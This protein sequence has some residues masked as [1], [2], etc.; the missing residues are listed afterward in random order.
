M[1]RWLLLGFLAAALAA[2]SFADV[3]AG[4]MAYANGDFEKALAELL[5][6]AEAGDLLAQFTIA[7]MY[8]TGSG[9]AQDDAAAVEWYGR[10]AVQG[11]RDSQYALGYMLLNGRGVDVPDETNACRWFRAAAEQNHPA[12]QYQLGYAYWEGSG[13]PHDDGEAVS[14]FERAAEQQNPNAQYYLGIAYQEG[15][16][17]GRNEATAREWFS[18]A[19]GQGHAK[20]QYRYGA[21]LSEGIGGEAD[22][23]EAV[24]WLRKAA[25]RGVAEAQ[26]ELGEAYADG[27]GVARDDGRAAEFYLQ[28]AKQGNADAQNRLGFAYANGRGVPQDYQEAVRWYRMAIENSHQGALSGLRMLFSAGD[29]PMADSEAVELY[30][31]GSELGIGPA[32]YRLAEAYREGR[33]VEVNEAEAARWY[34]AAAEQGHGESQYRLAVAYAKGRGVP[35]D[36][37]E[38]LRW[39]R[40]AADQGHVEAQLQMAYVYAQGDGVPQSDATSVQWYRLAAENGSAIAQYNLGFAYANG[41]GVPNDDQEAVRW[42]RMAADQGYAD[43]QSNLGFMLFN[44]RGV[45]Q[46]YIQAH[47][48][49]NLAA[50]QGDDVAQKNRDALAALMTPEQLARAQELAGN[51]RPGGTD[52]VAESGRGASMTGPATGSGETDAA[53]DYSGQPISSATGFTVSQEGHIVTV[54]HMLAGCTSVSVRGLQPRQPAPVLLEDA[55]TNLA[56]LGPVAS[57]APPLAFSDNTD[58]HIGDD[59]VVATYPLGARQSES[60]MVTTGELRGTVGPGG[61]TRMMQLT[62]PVGQGSDGG[63]LL[64]ASGNAI[65]MVIS[66]LN[67]LQPDDF[68]SEYGL[69]IKVEVVRSLLDGAGVRYQIRPSNAP[70]EVTAAGEAAKQSAVIV[71]CW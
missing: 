33:G 9:V 22:A 32:Q 11:N 23:A 17:T 47:M 66:E 53:P 41:T 57:P 58:F 6:A 20:A 28:A 40:S 63:P 37:A 30:R 64:D 61:D 60:M 35:V 71:E 26:Y 36:A 12:A 38:S 56:L 1:R 45:P 50:S 14:W 69:A 51:W 13:L 4:M 19:A 43:A 34:L 49:T 10:A 39:Y 21:M 44:G 55:A 15:R 46:D 24:N 48:W 68:D 31:V 67:P 59:V 8:W 18:R 29:L 27:N 54:A 25:E 5:P 7:Y 42:Y 65:G 3:E 2:P 70:L 16:G 62:V 52:A